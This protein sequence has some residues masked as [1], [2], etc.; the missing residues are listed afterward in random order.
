MRRRIYEALTNPRPDDTAARVVSLVLLLLIAANVAANVLETDVELATRASSFFA[1]FEIVSVAAFTLEY[2]LRLWACTSDPRFS[3]GL[4]GR[5]RM[6]V[7]PM[8]L[9]D[10]A[11]IAPFYF[12]LFLAATLDLRFL[13]ALRLMR[14][15]RLLRVGHLANS[16]AMLTRVVQSKRAELGVTLAVVGI[17]V[18]LAAGAIYVAEHGEPGTEFT[19]IPRA[20]WWSIIT[21]TTVGYGDMAPET[22]PGRI[23]GG[24]V[25]FVGICAL[26]LPVGILS[27]GFFHELNRAKSPPPESSS[28]TCPHCGKTI[29]DSALDR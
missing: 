28:R 9:V 10:L 14:L 26:A 20:M 12:D 27:T 15:F 21:I 2:V 13:R 17:A 24:L 18:L 8:S 29:D 4:K 16:F 6:A 25:A 3:D 11:A 1:W 7:R 5:L 22:S 19:S 23:I